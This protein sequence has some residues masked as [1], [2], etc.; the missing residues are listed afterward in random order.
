MDAHKKV[1]ADF[2][3]QWVNYSDNEGYDGSQELF[4][5]FVEPLLPVSE[6]FGK[7]TAE[8]GAGTGRICAMMLEAG[9]AE[10][11]AVEPSEAIEPLKRNL[12]KYGERAHAVQVMGDAI[13]N[14]QFD[15]ILS[16][17]VLHHIP[18]PAPTMKAAYAALRPGGK[19]LAWLYGR[20]GNGIYLAFALP[21]R[22]VT[23]RA[24]HLVNAALARIL[25]APLKAYIVASRHMPLF[26]HRYMTGYLDKLT[27]DK[28]RLV[29]YDQLKLE[30][31]KY[32]TRD[33]AHQL[34]AAA[35]FGNIQLHHRGG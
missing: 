1:I 2:G 14:G 35:G 28:R 23:K 30:W 6:F 31:A 25:D 8:I 5:D 11:T 34:F 29:I 15:I 10:V 13:P 17:G 4:R 18:D 9:A 12:A 24:P 22:Q 19:M 7:R 16:Y 21:L 32:Y 3:Q 26:L 27:P 20:E 33:E